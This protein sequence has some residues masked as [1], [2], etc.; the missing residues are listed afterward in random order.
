MQ[1]RGNCAKTDRFGPTVANIVPRP[2]SVPSG[3]DPKLIPPMD[4]QMQRWAYPNNF[5]ISV[6]YSPLPGP[7][8]SKLGASSVLFMGSL[9]PRLVAA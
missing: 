1:S 7:H 3:Q 2:P 4:Q 9:W 8:A 5:A 6:R